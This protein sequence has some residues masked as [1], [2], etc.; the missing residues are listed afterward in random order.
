MNVKND[1]DIIEK[2]DDTELD[3]DGVFNTDSK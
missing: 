1:D 2:C 3:G